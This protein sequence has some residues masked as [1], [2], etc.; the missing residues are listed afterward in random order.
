MQRLRYRKAGLAAPA[1]D[2]VKEAFT[3]AL[4]NLEIVVSSG[5]EDI[6]LLLPPQLPLD[7]GETFLFGAL[8]IAFLA[9]NPLLPDD[10]ACTGYGGGELSLELCLR[11]IA[12]RP[13][14]DGVSREYRDQYRVV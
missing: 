2:D 7:G 11:R 6:T 4:Y 14:R 9:G 8:A 12:G 3:G 1:P 13:S 5:V 10:I